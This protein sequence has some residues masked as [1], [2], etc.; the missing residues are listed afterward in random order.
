MR[1][2]QRNDMEQTRQLSNKKIL[3]DQFLWLKH[4]RNSDC[5]N[6]NT[7]SYMSCFSRLWTLARSFSHL[8]PL[9]IVHK[10]LSAFS[11]KKHVFCKGNNDKSR[12]QTVGVEIWNCTPLSHF[13]FNFTFT[14]GFCTTF[15]IFHFGSFDEAVFTSGSSS[16]FWPALQIST[17]E[18]NSRLKRL[19]SKFQN[20][21]EMCPPVFSLIGKLLPVCHRFSPVS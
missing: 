15:S 20:L 5:Q 21:A 3:D 16:G 11:A 17:A 19:F 10:S 4:M 12:N 13:A 14:A 9:N 6:V 8:I 1:F 7:C 18:R 2:R